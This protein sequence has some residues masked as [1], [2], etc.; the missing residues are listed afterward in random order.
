VLSWLRGPDAHWN[1]YRHEQANSVDSNLVQGLLSS[2]SATDDG[3]F[4][5][6]P[7][8]FYKVRAVAACT[9]EEAD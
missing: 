7:R 6:T 2:P 8:L 1:L 3:I 5:G 4:S 9:G